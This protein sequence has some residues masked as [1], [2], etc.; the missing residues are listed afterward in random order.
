MYQLLSGTRKDSKI[1]RHVV[2]GMVRNKALY[3]KDAI[4]K[5]T[6]GLTRRKLIPREVT[7]EILVEYLQKYGFKQEVVALLSNQ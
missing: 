1:P 3:M 7:K 2:P 4:A 6:G 5:L